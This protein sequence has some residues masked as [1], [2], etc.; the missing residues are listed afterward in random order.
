MAQLLNSQASTLELM[1]KLEES[2]MFSRHSQAV[3]SLVI[4]FTMAFSA[5]GKDD[6]FYECG[7]HSECGAGQVCCYNGTGSECVSA[8]NCEETSPQDPPT[9]QNP[10][11]PTSTGAPTGGS[12]SEVEPGNG[13]YLTPCRSQSD[14]GQD[15]TC[16]SDECLCVF[17]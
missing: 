6:Q 2:L 7:T 8:T 3:L 1:T 13:Q 12:C 16:A 14:C 17:I 10:T 15:L 5:C 11:S 4:L 9:D